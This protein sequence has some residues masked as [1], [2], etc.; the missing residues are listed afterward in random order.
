MN[1]HVSNWHLRQIERR[2]E[3]LDEEA[4]MFADNYDLYN[5]KPPTDDNL[6]EALRG[7]NKQFKQAPQDEQEKE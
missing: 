2:K 4:A 5:V 7:S 3:E 6:E 1:G